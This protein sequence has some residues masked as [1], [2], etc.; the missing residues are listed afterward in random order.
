MVDS[1]YQPIFGPSY[2]SSFFNLNNGDEYPCGCN[3]ATVTLYPPKCYIFYGDFDFMGSPTQIIMTAISQS[4]SYLIKAR[5]LFN[6]PSKVGKWISVYVKAYA[7][8][9]N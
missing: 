4:A 8:N 6:N 1:T 7:G 9:M 5:I 2:A 3:Q